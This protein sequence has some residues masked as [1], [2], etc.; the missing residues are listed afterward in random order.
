MKFK[1]M[2]YEDREFPF[3]HQ[4]GVESVHDHPT[5]VKWSDNYLAFSR[6]RNNQKEGFKV[7]LDGEVS[8]LEYWSR[9]YEDGLKRNKTIEIDSKRVNSITDSLDSSENW[10]DVKEIL[11]RLNNITNEVKA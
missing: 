5:F 6:A 2:N 7:E 9:R 10:N 4:Y 11:G 8:E 3:D 1:Y